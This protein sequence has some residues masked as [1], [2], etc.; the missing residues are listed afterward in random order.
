MRKIGILGGTFDPIHEGHIN[1]A[2]EAMVQYNL[3]EVRFLTG[4]IPPHKRDKKIT[5]PIIRHRM[6]EL[7]TEDIKGFVADDFELS[8]TEYTY[9]VNI[10]MELKELNPDWDIHFI[11]GEDSLRDFH[12]WHKPEEITKLSKLLVYPRDNSDIGDLVK[13][14]RN[15]FNA[16]IEIIDAKQINVSSTQIREMIK[17][18]EDITGLVPIKVIEYI[19]EKGLYKNGN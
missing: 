11:I 12:L 7:A 4:G 14:R 6:C 9:S 17:K 5:D 2:K 8:K 1:I 19:K 15:E 10:L 13:R 3:F 16:Q 18:G